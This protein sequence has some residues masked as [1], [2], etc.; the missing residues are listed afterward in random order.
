VEE[1]GRS[2]PDFCEGAAAVAQMKEEDGK[3]GKRGEKEALHAF[4]SRSHSSYYRGEGAETHGSEGEG[5]GG[6]RKKRGGIL[7]LSFR[8]AL[9]VQRTVHLMSMVGACREGEGEEGGGGK[10]EKGTS[11]SFAIDRRKKRKKKEEGRR[12]P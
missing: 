7:N 11:S 6:E 4:K 2:P 10:R 1:R 5:G 9:P 12:D 3:E 8:A